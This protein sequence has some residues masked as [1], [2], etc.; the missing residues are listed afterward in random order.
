MIKTKTDTIFE[1]TRT[2]PQE[3]LQFKLIV[4]RKTFSFI[5]PSE[6]VEDRWMTGETNLEVFKSLSD[7][8]KKCTFSNFF[9]WIK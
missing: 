1:Q 2:R 5:V 4:S 8:R 6:L 9:S 3:T 7:R